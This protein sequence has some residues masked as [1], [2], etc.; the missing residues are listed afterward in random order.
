MHGLMSYRRFGRA[1]SLR[2]DRTSVRARSLRSDRAPARAWS[3]RS[4]RAE[5]TFG[6]YVATEPW[7]ELGR[8]VATERSTCSVAAQ[9]SIS[10]SCSMTRVSSAKLFVKKNLFRKS[11]CRRRFL[12]FLFGDLDVN[13]VATVFDPNK[14]MPMV[15]F[16]EYDLLGFEKGA[17]MK[18]DRTLVRARSL[19]SDRAPASSGS[20]S[21][22]TCLLVMC[23]SCATCMLASFKL[24]RECHKLHVCFLDKSIMCKSQAI[25]SSCLQLSSYEG[26]ESSWAVESDEAGLHLSTPFLALF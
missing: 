19:R 18:S 13:F 12:R 20:S 8:F 23:M 6:R 3:L 15:C 22:A 1:R 16:G 17:I 2:S 24:S 7:L 21:V 5:W 9:R 11:I 25:C 10:S 26:N 14:Y 4:D